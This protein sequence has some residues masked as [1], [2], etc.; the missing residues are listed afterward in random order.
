MC[1][2]LSGWC[3]VHFEIGA[4]FFIS[5]SVRNSLCSIFLEDALPWPQAG[6]WWLCRLYRKDIIWSQ[7]YKCRSACTEHVRVLY[8]W[9]TLACSKIVHLRTIVIMPAA[10]SWCIACFQKLQH[11]DEFDTTPFFL[12]KALT[13]ETSIY[14]TRCSRYRRIGLLKSCSSELDDLSM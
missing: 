5:W 13:T 1:S 7:W 14:G 9:Y 11:P 12:S 3:T 2:W 10:S 4:S 6:W 8:V